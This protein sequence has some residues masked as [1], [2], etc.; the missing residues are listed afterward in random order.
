MHGYWY[1]IL[2]HSRDWVLKNQ[3]WFIMIPRVNNMG[4][5][6]D[7][8]C[9]INC[10]IVF[11][12][13][14][15]PL[16]KL[17]NPCRVSLCSCNLALFYVPKWLFLYNYNYTSHHHHLSWQYFLVLNNEC[18][19]GNWFTEVSLYIYICNGKWWSML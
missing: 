13:Q 15:K 9:K 11:V 4:K 17:C 2:G 5:T 16:N 10:M 6:L 19:H 1:G 7:D 14:S 18:M 3:Q 12:H 8:T